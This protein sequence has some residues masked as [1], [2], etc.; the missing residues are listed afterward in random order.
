MRKKEDLKE[1]NTKITVTCLPGLEDILAE[2]ITNLGAKNVDKQRRAVLCEGDL[3]LIYSLN[4]NCRF[5]LRVLVHLEHQAIRDEEHMYRA[6]HAIDWP[7]HFEC[8]NTIAV[9][10]A[11]GRHS[12]KNTHYFS[13]KAKDAIVDRFRAVD[14]E[15]PSIDTKSPD[16]GIYLY[17]D[18]GELDI[19]LDSSGYSLHKRGYKRFLGQASI[20]ETLAAAIFRWAEWKEGQPILNPMCG[21]GTLGIEAA[22]AMSN[23]SSQKNRSTFGF[24]NWL[25]YDHDLYE[26]VRSKATEANPGEV[27]CTDLDERTIRECRENIEEVNMSEFMTCEQVDFFELEPVDNAVILLNPPYDIRMR[28]DD[29]IA[30]Y[31]KIGDTLKFKWKNCR[32]VIISA[33]M[34]AFKFIGLRP[35]KKYKVFNG[36][37]PAEVRIFDI[38]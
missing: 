13:L 14:G 34:D 25:N 3:E 21:I 18:S 30:F 2:E 16:V 22:L 5:A 24:R 12:F 37:L 20:S 6:M 31:K 19:Y 29:V 1:N 28:E 35:N 32:C 27:Q 36:P 8:S 23:Q 26:Q 17:C 7:S 9:R 33:N 15:R 4:I 11:F 38:Y 10:A